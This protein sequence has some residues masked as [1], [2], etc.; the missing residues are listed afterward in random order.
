M[1][2]NN[3]NADSVKMK[4]LT[5]SLLILLFASF[6]FY[7][8]LK[9]PLTGEDYSLQPWNYK[10]SPASFWGQVNAI[11]HKVMLSATF[12]SPRI[13]EALSTLTAAFPKVIFDVLNTIMCIWLIFV[14]FFIGFGR[15][16]N[17]EK[18][19]DSFT[20]FSIFLL[21]ISL[22]PLL[23]QLFFW[24]AGTTNHIWGL[25]ILLSFTL[26]FRE[27][28]H[29]RTR[30]KG[31]I[32]LILYILLGFFAGLTVENASVVVLGCL[33]IYYVTGLKRKKIDRIF[34]FPIV[35]FAV[36]VAILLFSSGTKTR[37]NY[38]NSLGFEGKVNWIILYLNRL[39]RI[40]SDIIKISWPLLVA[41]FIC[42]II[43]FVIS[44]HTKQT[45][46]NG[47]QD[48]E[49]NKLTISE[50][51]ITAFISFLSV[52]VLISIAYYSD[53]QRGFAFF[54]LILISLSA[55]L[56]TEIWNQFSSRILKPFLIISVLGVLIFQMFNMGMV[57]NQFNSENSR[58]VEIIYAALRKGERKVVL[59]KFT[60]KDS[61]II[62]TRK[63]L[64][65]DMGVRLAIYY[66][67]E[68]VEITK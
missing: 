51:L 40:I 65:D 44:H 50:I 14:L 11:S 35:S 64:T 2:N 37:I 43:Y 31:K 55:A 25:I 62:E 9:M 59:P 56:M 13:G 57:Y 67:F 30:I 20:V 47:P 3:L 33:L 52:L 60:T 45:I 7:I 29:K 22:F 32:A 12:W 19:K 1:I 18:S 38:Y 5:F 23:G 58:R 16:P 17:W 27:N 34:V 28:L 63:I 66:G 42:L 8:N 4:R 21:I 6:L 53:Q 46:S 49:P 48:E 39:I 10:S 68:T 26:P 61:R 54:W 41:F 24:K 15:F 36:G